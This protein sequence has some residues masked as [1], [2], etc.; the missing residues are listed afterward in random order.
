MYIT[1]LKEQK[2]II[3]EKN[4]IYAYNNMSNKNKYSD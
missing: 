4:R 2:D 3:N 1:I